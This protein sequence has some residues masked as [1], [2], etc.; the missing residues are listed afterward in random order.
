MF[1]IDTSR[2]YSFRCQSAFRAVVLY[3]S[4]FILSPYH[5]L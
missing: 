2:G 5:L 1:T 4:V 3:F